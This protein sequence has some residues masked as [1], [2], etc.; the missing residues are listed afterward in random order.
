MFE[1]FKFEIYKIV[2]SKLFVISLF[3]V[4]V[5]IFVLIAGSLSSV[6]SYD[7]SGNAIN[8]YNAIEYEKKFTEKNS[9]KI[10]PQKIAEVIDTYNL[11]A[12]NSENLNEYNTIKDSV[13]ISELYQYRKIISFIAVVYTSP[14]LQPDYN[15]IKELSYDDG[16]IFYNLRNEQI[17]AVLDMDYSYG[18]YSAEEKAAIIKYNENVTEPFDFT[19][20]LGWENL[21]TYAFPFYVIL[22]FIACVNISSVFSNEFQN[23]TVDVILS[24]KHGRN[25][26]F[27]AKIISALLLSTLVFAMFTVV[28]FFAFVAVYGFEGSSVS[29]QT[30][31]LLSVYNLTLGETFVAIVGIS[32]VTFILV[33]FFTLTISAICKNNFTSV[34]LSLALFFIPMFFNYSKSSKL[35]NY[36]VDLFPIKA[37]NTFEMFKQYKLYGLAGAYIRQPYFMI[38]LMLILSAISFAATKSIYS[39]CKVNS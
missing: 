3:I 10:T 18:N 20:A 1:I 23:G 24:S 4:F 9:G 26:V 29:I 28:Y 33:I 16:L 30:L 39:R 27:Y 5:T 22:T 13:Y 32:Y 36:V 12:N 34:L 38:I 31:S 14:G 6:S 35:F 19:Y 8:G 15:V 37:L 2:K 11:I 21:L 7:N 17:Q 25:K